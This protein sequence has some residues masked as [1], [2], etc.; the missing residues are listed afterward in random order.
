V[1][2]VEDSGALMAVDAGTG[3][4]LWHF[5]TSQTVRA[6]PMTY[7]F[8]GRQYVVLASGPNV[9]AFALPDGG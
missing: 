8:D 2:F 4:P 1:F 5:Q 6:S 7:V 9:I 3:D